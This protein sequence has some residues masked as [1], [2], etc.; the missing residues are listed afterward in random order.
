MRVSRPTTASGR[1]PG[2]LAVV[3]EH[4]G[5]GNAEVQG[6]LCG[7]L[8]VGQTPDPVGAEDTRHTSASRAISAC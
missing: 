6:Q 3:D 8:T 2:E 5:S 4:A 7:Q 1:L